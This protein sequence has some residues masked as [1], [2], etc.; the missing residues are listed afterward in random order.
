MIA[1][2]YTTNLDSDISEEVN[3]CLKTGEGPTKLVKIIHTFIA[4]EGLLLPNCSYMRQPPK[5]HCPSQRT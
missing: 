3:Q 4:L 2:M 1:S 5:K